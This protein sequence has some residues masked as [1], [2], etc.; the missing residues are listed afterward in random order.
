MRWPVLRDL[1]FFLMGI[2]GIIYQQFSGKVSIE[3]LFVY[4]VLL[5]VPMA[6]ALSRLHPK[7]NHSN[8][9]GAPRGRHAAPEPREKP[10]RDREPPDM[11]Q[12]FNA[13]KSL[14]IGLAA[15]WLW[16]REVGK[17]LHAWAQRIGNRAREQPVAFAGATLVGAVA[18]AY[19]LMLAVGRPSEKP[20]VLP[21]PSGTPSL[22]PTPTPSPTP[23]ASPT[24]SPTPT[25]T[26]SPSEPTVSPSIVEVPP[27]PPVTVTITRTAPA[28]APAPAPTPTVA[29][30]A[31]TSPGRT[32][33]FI[34]RG[35]RCLNPKGLI[36]NGKTPGKAI[37]MW[38]IGIR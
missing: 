16:L 14:V 18:V 25:P 1:T 26:A 9:N 11:M 8:D 19:V 13:V 29:P 31:P 17:H 5:G 7:V 27:P 28:P 35:D 22:A 32:C 33:I 12:M 36:K 21:Y 24:V 4:M 34:K 23:T 15:L 2:G 37:L 38:L 3:L 10:S 20:T 6:T 30:V